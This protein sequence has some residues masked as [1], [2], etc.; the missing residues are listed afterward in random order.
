MVFVIAY[1]DNGF[2]LPLVFNQLGPNLKIYEAKRCIS[3]MECISH[4]H[5]WDFLRRY[6]LNKNELLEHFALLK[7][8]SHTF[9][10]VFL[11]FISLGQ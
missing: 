5:L 11:V 10:L 4:H 7:K 1:Y 8:K 6:M 9:V 3:Q 2:Y